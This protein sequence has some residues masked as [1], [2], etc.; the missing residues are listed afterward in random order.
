M[1]KFTKTGNFRLHITALDIISPHARYKVWV[2][3]NG[4]MPFIYG[5]N[6]V[7]AHV[8]RWSGDCLQYQGVVVYN[9]GDTPLGFGV[10]ARS[11]AESLRAGPTDIVV[12]RQGDVGEYLREEDTL[13]AG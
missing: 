8:G 3:S 9:M 11:T 10:T 7:K 5:G 6:V 1:G 4:E 13:F 2:K 12:F